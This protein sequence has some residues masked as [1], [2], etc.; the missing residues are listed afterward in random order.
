MRYAKSFFGIFLISSFFLLGFGLPRNIE[1]KVQKELKNTFKISQFSLNPIEVSATLNAELP[2]KINANNFFK[3]SNGIDHLG[4][5]F[6][7]E[8]LA[9]T[10]NFD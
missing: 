10:S 3:I 6:V 9:K 7:D 5:I 8:A 4:Y 1:K 2:K